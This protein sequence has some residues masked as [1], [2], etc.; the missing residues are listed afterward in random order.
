MILTI[1]LVILNIFLLG[2]VL[3]LRKD[4]KRL[5][6]KNARLLERIRD[7]K[8]SIAYYSDAIRKVMGKTDLCR[9]QLRHLEELKETKEIQAGQAYIYLTKICI[10][11]NYKLIK[12]PELLYWIEDLK[13]E[14]FFKEIKEV[15]HCV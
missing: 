2:K 14:V 12:I 6:N 15:K 7:L 13:D 10:K 11:W 8:Q 3:C 9:H 5:N 1:L 4:F